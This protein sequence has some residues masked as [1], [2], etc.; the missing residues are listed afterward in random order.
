MPPSPSWQQARRLGWSNLI[1][2]L[3]PGLP[4]PG[5]ALGA[6]TLHNTPFPIYYLVSNWEL[7]SECQKK[8]FSKGDG[9][10]K[11]TWEERKKTH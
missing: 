11:S 1:F 8:G 5:E 9:Q 10:A 6:Q 7:K 4:Q 3:S 2:V